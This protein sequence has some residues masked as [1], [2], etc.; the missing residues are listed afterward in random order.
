MFLK[1]EKNNEVFIVKVTLVSKHLNKKK[2]SAV[3]SP[4]QVSHLISQGQ[5]QT[6]DFLLI[7]EVIF[8]FFWSL[9]KKYLDTLAF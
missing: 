4:C 2:K 1:Q 7:S 5:S 3:L 6:L 9:Y 8:F